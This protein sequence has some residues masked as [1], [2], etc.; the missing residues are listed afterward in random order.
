MTSKNKPRAAQAVLT[1]NLKP[2][3]NTIEAAPYAGVEPHTLEK[4]RAHHNLGPKHL[5]I[6]SRVF[7]DPDDIAEWRD[8]CRIASTAENDKFQVAA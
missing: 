7:Y 6:G 3:L 1:D 2:L 5:K 8:T 4:W